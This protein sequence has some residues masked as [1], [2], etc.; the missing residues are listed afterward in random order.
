MELEGKK[1]N[2]QVSNGDE[3][4]SPNDYYLEPRHAGNHQRNYSDQ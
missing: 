3:A 1:L 4:G 2:Y